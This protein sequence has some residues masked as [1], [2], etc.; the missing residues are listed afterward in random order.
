MWQHIVVGVLVLAA[1]AY[2]ARKL[3]PRR[4]RAKQSGAGTAGAAAG[5]CGCSKDG[6]AC[7]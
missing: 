1:T 4:W 3:G 5:N 7:H 2:A 6:K